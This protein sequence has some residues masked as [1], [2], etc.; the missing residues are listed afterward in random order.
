M[1]EERTGW[2]ARIAA[3]VALGQINIFL[4]MIA[5]I[6]L[7]AAAIFLT[8][9]WLFGPKIQLEHSQYSRFTAS[10]DG[11]IVESWVALEL[12]QSR[13]RLSEFW[14]ASATAS[15][16]VVIELPSSSGAAAWGAAER[17][18]FCGP[19]LDFNT[20]YT[21][22]D[23]REITPGI[24]FGWT[25]D[26]HGFAIPE[27]RMDAATHRWLASHPAHT[28]MHSSWPASNELEWLMLELDRPVD[29]AIAGWSAP[30]AIL[31]VQFDPSHP[32]RPLPS[33]IV[34]K[35][36]ATRPHW[37]A[38]IVFGGL[39]L[40]L[41][42]TG[43]RL[44]PQIASL[45]PPWQWFV[46]V[47]PLLSMPTWIDTFP[48]FLQ[49]MSAQWTSVVADMLGD[50]D[51]LDRLEATQ[52]S[53]ALLADGVRLR[54]VASAG[55]YKDTFG[56]VAPATPASRGLEPDASLLALSDAVAS[57]VRAL[58]VG[59]RVELFERLRADKQRDLTSAGIA[60]LAAARECQ[61]QS[62]GMDGRAAEAFLTEWYVSP[63]ESPDPHRL[64]FEARKTLSQP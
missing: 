59:Q 60:F 18:A 62:N 58:S 5:A 23:L 4:M 26:E 21:L 54:W 14:R 61:R 29:Q 24:P 55:A 56:R 33:G 39:G 35:R 64:A 8:T 46:M 28:F 36:R 25:R 32:E 44:V 27:I 63:V 10:S 41:W 48:R 37:P 51:P 43:F 52:P 31:P 49:P 38:V 11:R 13:V 9:A 47:L 15:P 12:D 53:G 1:K 30:A 6:V 7:G 22:A 19:R 40:W 34:A 3:I 17:R 50:I 57:R 16:C 2:L 45:A 42:V 20:S